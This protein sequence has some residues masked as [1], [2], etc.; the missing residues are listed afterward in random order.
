MQFAQLFTPKDDLNKPEK[1]LHWLSLTA[2][3]LMAALA[4]HGVLSTY[5]PVSDADIWDGLM[6]PYMHIQDG[7]WYAWW[8]QH[9]E[10]RPIITR[11]LFWV[12]QTWFAASGLFLFASNLSIL[13]LMAALFA[14]LAREIQGNRYSWFSWLLCAWLFLYTQAELFASPMASCFYLAYLLPLA[15]LYLLHRS[16]SG[17]S[18]R[19]SS[20]LFYTSLVCGIAAIGSQGNGLLT[21]PL[22][23]VFAWVVKMPLARIAWMGVAMAF[24]IAVYFFDYATPPG[25]G[26]LDQ[27]LST[28]AMNVVVFVF[29]FFGSPFFWIVGKGIPGGVAAVV[30]GGLAPGEWGLLDA[31]AVDARPP[32]LV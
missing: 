16:A 21:L 10:H 20:Q 9:C 11:L 13:A 2:A 24:C 7:D 19:H 28:Q 29:G 5:T 31:K 12:D 14:L 8:M 3:L 23:L 30:A 17:P 15:A 6:T 18:S 1:G 26:S 27:A 4:V 22:M 25:L 32:V